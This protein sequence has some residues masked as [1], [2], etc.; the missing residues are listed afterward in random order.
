MVRGKIKAVRLRGGYAFLGR[1]WMALVRATAVL[2]VVRQLAVQPG[3]R[4]GKPRHAAGRHAGQA[5]GRARRNRQ[6][7]PRHASA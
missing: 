5:R 4:R 1:A 6:N 7:P 3:S 2:L